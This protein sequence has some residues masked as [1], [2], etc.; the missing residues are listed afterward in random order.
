MSGP[1]RVGDIRNVGAVRNL[2]AASGRAVGLA[3]LG[4]V[5]VGLWGR[6]EVR[7]TLARERIVS[8]SEADLPGRPV[9]SGSAARA[10]AE[11]IRARTVEAAA[12]RTYAETDPYLQADGTTTSDVARALRDERTGEPVEN[13]AHLLW[14]QSTTLQTALMQAYMAARLAELI[15]GLGVAFVAIGAGLA[16]G[17]RLR[18]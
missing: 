2:P 15:T 10:L 12:G 18:R 9:T 6:R 3:G 14:L 13:P 17:A 1:A 5:G 11:L 4:L 8:P 16:G 7:V